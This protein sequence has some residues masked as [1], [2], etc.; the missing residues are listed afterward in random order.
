MQSR[1]LGSNA[2]GHPEAETLPNEMLERHSGGQ[3]LEH[4]CLRSTGVLERTGELPVE[5]QLRQ[6]HLMWLGHLW[7]MPDHSIQ[8]Q[9]MR[10]GHLAG[11]DQQEE[12]H[13]DGAI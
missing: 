10:F 4:T 11:G 13:Y 7:R 3:P 2:A 5:D 9:L 1:D 8:K 12:H 6:R